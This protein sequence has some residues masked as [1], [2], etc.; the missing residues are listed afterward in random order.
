M[1]FNFFGISIPQISLPKISLPSLP[2]LPKVSLPAPPKIE[3]PKITVPDVQRVIPKIITSPIPVVAVAGAVGESVAGAVAGGVPEIKLPTPPKVELPKISLPKIDLPKPAWSGAG[4]VPGR[5]ITPEEAARTGIPTGGV[6]VPAGGGGGNL[7]DTIIN[8]RDKS[9]SDST[10]HIGAGNIPRG[11]AQFGATAAADVLLPM[12]LADAANKWATGRG[13]QID[14]ELALWA[15]IDAVTLAAAPFTFGAS[16]A[17][18]RALKGAKVVGKVGKTAKGVEEM[19]KSKVITKAIGALQGAGKA[20]GAAKA[21][22]TTKTAIK[23]LK[24]AAPGKVTSNTSNISALMRKQAEAAQK[25]YASLQKQMQAQYSKMMSSLK[26]PKSAPVGASK[27]LG[28]A[29]DAAQAAGKT[30]NLSKTRTALKTAGLTLGVGA[31]GLT[32]LGALGGPAQ[33]QEVPPGEGNGGEYP[34][35]YDPGYFPGYDPGIAY[36]GSED[37]WWTMPDLPGFEFPEIPG[38]EPPTWA[39]YPYPDGDGGYTDEYGNY[40]PAYPDPFGLEDYGQGLFGAAEEVPVVGGLAHAIRSRGL[41]VPVIVGVLVLVIL[42]LRSKRGKKLVGGAK[43][44]VSGVVS[45]AKKA[46]GA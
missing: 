40:P 38:F 7:I 5:I 42:F 46:V 22:G 25:Q 8:A 41:T 45:G 1:A 24:V 4:T 19:G 36:P 2:S 30:S 18:G 21:A 44:K 12:D 28:A 17:A 11:G 32:A 14:G 13:D 23:P 37:P 26:A 31:I 9:Y 43:K 15:A 39:D 3:I 34:P 33:A 6:T 16:Y 27:G 10:E 29:G 35:G 20:S